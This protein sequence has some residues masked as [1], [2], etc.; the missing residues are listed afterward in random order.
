MKRTALHYSLIVAGC[1]VL[2]GLVIVAFSRRDD[3]SFNGRRLSASVYDLLEPNSPTY[4][5]SS[6]VIA[7][8]GTRAIPYLKRTVVRGE[9]QFEQLARKFNLPLPAHRMMYGRQLAVCRATRI[10]GTNAT[11]LTSELLPLT[12]SHIGSIRHAALETLFLTSADSHLSL[13]TNALAKDIYI[14]CRLAGMRY[15]F[16][17]GM[18]PKEVVSLAVENI[19]NSAQYSGNAARAF[20][21]ELRAGA[22]AEVLEEVL[23]RFSRSSD[24]EVRRSS[25][26]GFQRVCAQMQ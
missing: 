17:S 18:D 21:E 12:Q 9:S 3:P 8:L 22:P 23:T 4:A 24:S 13:A 26:T 6:N 11:S 5:A 1:L 7:Q 14:E 19:A 10:L 25:P 2:F 15:A 20:A 16:A